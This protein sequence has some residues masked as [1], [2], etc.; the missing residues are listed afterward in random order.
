MVGTTNEQRLA[1]LQ[2]VA[3]LEPSVEGYQDYQVKTFSVNGK[4][5]LN[6]TIADIR[7]AARFVQQLQG[8]KPNE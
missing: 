3:A 5:I 6:I 7:A 2:A 4:P 1:V 8:G